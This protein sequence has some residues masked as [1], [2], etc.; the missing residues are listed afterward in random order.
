MNGKKTTESEIDEIIHLRKTGH[1][2]PEIR[3]ILG[4]GSSTVFKYIQGVKILPKYQESYRIKQGG[5][6]LRSSKKWAEAE[7]QIANVVTGLDKK[8][9]FLIAACLYWGEGTKKD[10]SLA[11]TDPGLIKAFI[12][13][14]EE[15][16]VTKD[17]LKI[18]VRIYEDIN[19]DSAVAFWSK[20]IG[21]PKKQVLNVN[22]LKGQKLG[23]LQ[24]GMCRVRVTKGEKYF[25]LLQSTIKAIKQKLNINPL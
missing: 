22:V 10:F 19:R 13:C 21:I 8:N 11:N 15:I 12:S 23:K 4:R 7:K 6:K 1:T 17:R 18:N 25:K 20:I 5:S 3:R 2:L 24:Y 16:G 9:K 14:L